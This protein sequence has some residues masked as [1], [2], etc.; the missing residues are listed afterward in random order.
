MD[1]ENSQTIK[2]SS[3][4]IICRPSFN[5]LHIRLLWLSL[6]PIFLG[7]NYWFSR[8]PYTKENWLGVFFIVIVFIF[9]VLIEYLKYRNN[10]LIVTSQGVELVNFICARQFIEWSSITFFAV[11]RKKDFWTGSHLYLFFEYWQDDADISGQYDL[12]F[13]TEREQDNVCIFFDKLERQLVFGRETNGF[14][15]EDGP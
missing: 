9:F 1:N 15:D 7:L 5:Y 8:Y 2:S 13:L 6:F 12:S 11:R 3:D 4:K 14:D 10:R